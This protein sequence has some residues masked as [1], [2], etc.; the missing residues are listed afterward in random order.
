MR[1][2]LSL[3]ILFTMPLFLSAQNEVYNSSGTKEEFSSEKIE[4]EFTSSNVQFPR[5]E[6]A[7]IAATLLPIAVDVGFKL[8]TSSLE[9]RV[10]KFT[11]ELSKHK[12]NIDAGDRTVPNVKFSR[13]ITL[14]TKETAFSLDISAHDVANVEGF[15]YTV[16]E[17]NLKYAG[18]KVT[19]T[20]NKLDYTIEIK[21]TLLVNGEKKSIDIAPIVISSISFGNT[22]FAVSEHRSDIIALPKNAIM[23]E[24]SIKVIESNPAKI[25]AEKILSIWNDN[26]ESAKTIINTFIS[27]EEDEDEE[28][29]SESDEEEGNQE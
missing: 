6:A 16:D 1:N 13:E 25:R 10:K 11:A 28:D 7:G 18:A 2:L 8:I 23:T 14:K 29:D 27:N 15:Y 5:K 20:N 24:I 12:S 19:K 4:I 22:T 9:G 3:L 26:K 21:P 17:I